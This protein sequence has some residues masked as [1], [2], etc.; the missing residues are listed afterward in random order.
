MSLHVHSDPITA[1]KQAK[2]F[3]Y[4]SLQ[5]CRAKSAR[6]NQRA[7]EMY[8]NHPPIFAIRKGGHD[9]TRIPL[10]EQPQ[11]HQRKIIF[12]GLLQG[13]SLFC[14]GQNNVTLLGFDCG[15]TG[16]ISL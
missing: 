8:L 3:F 14:S 16:N 2:Y 1:C 4:V 13:S 10:V 12:Y 6:P 11:I 15:H 9:G 7:T 5:R